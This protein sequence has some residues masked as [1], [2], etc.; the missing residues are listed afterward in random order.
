MSLLKQGLSQVTAAAKAG[1]SERT[2]GALLNEATTVIA[3]DPDAAQ[4]RLLRHPVGAAMA[5]LWTELQPP[6]VSA[7]PDLHPDK[8]KQK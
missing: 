3:A 4:Q 1:I 7:F 5:Q 6:I 8:L 2:V